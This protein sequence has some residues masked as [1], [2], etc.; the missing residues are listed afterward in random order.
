MLIHDFWLYFHGYHNN[1]ESSPF[2]RLAELTQ[3]LNFPPLHLA[4]CLRDLAYGDK[5]RTADLKA[6]VK[7]TDPAYQQMFRDAMWID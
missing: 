2:T 4:H 7:S 1:L 3:N 6:M 5:N